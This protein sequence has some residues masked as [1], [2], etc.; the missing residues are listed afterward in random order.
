M[1]RTAVGGVRRLSWLSHL[2]P[3]GRRSPT[4]LFGL[5]GLVQPSDFDRLGRDAVETC[6][7]LKAD[8]TSRPPSLRTIQDLDA[9]S[10]AVCGVIDAAELCR[11]VH[12]DARFRAAASASFQY[13]SSFIQELNADVDMYNCLRAVTDNRSLMAG[14]TEE[15]QRVG[16]LL[17][18]EFER[19]GIHLDDAG[20]R[21][22]MELQNAITRLSMQFQDNMHSVHSFIE[23]P[24]KALRMLPNG[25]LGQC[26]ASA[27]G[28]TAIPTTVPMTNSI[29]KWIPD[30]HVRKQM[31][32]AGNA[33]A[34]V[35]LQVLDDLIAARHALATLLGFPTYAHLATSDKMVGSPSRV[36]AFLRDIASNLMTKAASERA[37]LVAAKTKAEGKG[38]FPAPLPLESWDTP[39][40]MGM[41]KAQAFDL[42]ARVIASYFPLERCLEGL[43][44][45]CSELFG[46][47]M[48]PEDSSA[49]ESWHDDVR[50]L[51]LT[52]DGVDLGVLYLDLFPRQHK[53]H[54]A[55][56]F[57]VRCGKRLEDGSYQTPIVALVCNFSP[58]S[59]STPSLLTHGEVETLFHEFGHAL[60]SL[61]SRTEFQHLSG[62][63]G[64]LDF[65]ETPSHLF[66]YF[67]W[68]ERVVQRFA[69]H[70]ETHHPIPASMLANL[71][72]S[73]HM[74]SAMETQTQCL[75]SLLD[76]TLFRDQPLPFSPPTTTQA[77]KEL[78]NKATLVPYVDGTHWHTRFGH[79]VGYGA[80]Y[81]S[82]LY[83]RVFAAEIWG[84]CFAEDPWRPA[85]GR[86][87][88]DELF[89]H[90]GA[91]EPLAMLTS[92]VG[93][94]PTSTRFVD[95][96]G[97]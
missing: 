49:P 29:L 65:V 41:L 47:D 57:T 63:R 15:Q 43:G 80:G 6:N 13:L 4:G 91:K 8:L 48:T 12:P 56:H 21:R 45:L 36:D 93:K 73:K 53:Y 70:Y 75:Y 30:A 16:M 76:L 69:K 10:N 5:Q 26:H 62:T 51:R 42:D 44:L 31:Y 34:S 11:N 7:R 87:V 72:A 61:L 86:L 2:A 60:H 17:R 71:K 18:A 32:I 89:R 59:A 37:L 81:Y 27:N 66:E 82:Y 97:V 95:E 79:L 14:F 77:L 52:K 67:A 39:Y 50:K 84:A 83:A 23:V 1:L 38:F 88:Y 78:Q 19:D 33:C 68:D 3:R 40:Y 55:A 46:V 94:T 28:T 54:H 92:I 74:F 35:N 85:S 25:L 9:I 22:V 20:R 90:G 96:L 58:P 64:Q 24:T